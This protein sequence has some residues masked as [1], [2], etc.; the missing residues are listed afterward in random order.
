MTG[1]H[2]TPACPRGRGAVWAVS[3]RTGLRGSRDV[4]AVSPWPPS[5]LHG[6][7]G[8]EPGVGGRGGLGHLHPQRP[9]HVLQQAADRPPLQ[10]HGLGCP[11]R[12]AQVPPGSA[13]RRAPGRGG[14]SPEWEG[15]SRRGRLPAG[16]GRPCRAK[17]VCHKPSQATFLFLVLST[18]EQVS[19]VGQLQGKCGGQ[20][21]LAGGLPHP[22]LASGGQPET[23]G[24]Q[25]CH[26]GSPSSHGASCVQISLWIRTPVILDQGP[27]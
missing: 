12:D 4:T 3:C 13:G 9:Q 18:E 22:L 14:G 17:Q 15:F 2:R 20:R 25:T 7:G 23:C 8:A 21:Q 6:D 1:A 11:A 19:P 27:P 26:S 5:E 24:L 10:R 16:P